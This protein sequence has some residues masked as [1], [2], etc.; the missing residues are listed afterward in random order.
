MQCGF[1]MSGG[2]KKTKALTD[3]ANRKQLNYEEEHK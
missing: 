3:R 1:F 2:I